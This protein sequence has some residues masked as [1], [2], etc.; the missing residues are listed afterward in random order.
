MI[1]IMTIAQ[2]RGDRNL[3]MLFLTAYVF[4]LRVPSEALPIMKLCSGELQGQKPLIYL[5]NEQVHLRL[6]RRK[7]KPFGSLLKRSC[8][9]STCSK[10]CPVHVLWEFMSQQHDYCSPFKGIS[11]H[12]ALRDLRGILQ[13]LG[14][15][16]A[17]QAWRD[18]RYHSASHRLR[19]EVFTITADVEHI[20]CNRGDLI[21]VSHDVIGVGYGGA[22]IKAVT[23]A[24]GAFVSIGSASSCA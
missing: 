8:W 3:A 6:P 4:L 22:R 12:T 16:D 13:T 15:A 20:V 18:A 24:G 14:V 23:N 19:P 17:D 5:K 10:T 11:K 1:D 21:R 7:N 2:Q 9:C